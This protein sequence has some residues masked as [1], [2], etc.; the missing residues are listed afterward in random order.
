VA[1]R[2]ALYWDGPCAKQTFRLDPDKYVSLGHFHMPDT[3]TCGGKTYVRGTPA[4]DTSPIYF[5]S[6]GKY[7]PLP[8]QIKGERDV[9][10]A[11]SR[12]HRA[13][14]KTSGH[15]LG[16][17]ERARQRIRRAVR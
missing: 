6:G 11:W 14:N 12:L 3:V 10:Q 13:L 5:V 7:A 4:D 17:I 9:F 1:D 2:N 15:Q 8:N 16:R